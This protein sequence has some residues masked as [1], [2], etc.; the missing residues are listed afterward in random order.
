MQ[1]LGYVLLLV[2]VTAVSQGSSEPHSNRPNRAPLPFADSE[3]SLLPTNGRINGHANGKTNG[4]TNGKSNG[5]CVL[6]VSTII[7][8]RL[9]LLRQTS[10]PAASAELVHGVAV[11][12]DQGGQSFYK[13]QSKSPVAE[14]DNTLNTVR[15]Y[16]AV[17]HVHNQPREIRRVASNSQVF[18]PVAH[19]NGAFYSH[20]GPMLDFITFVTRGSKKRSGS[21]RDSSLPSLRETVF[22]KYPDLVIAAE[23]KDDPGHGMGP[24]PKH[25]PTVNDWVEW[26]ATYL[27]QVK[28]FGLPVVP[29]AKSGS[30][31]KYLQLIQKY[32][33]LLDGLILISPVH[34]SIKHH[35]DVARL[36]QFADEGEFVPNLWGFEWAVKMV[37]QMDFHKNPNPFNGVP[38]LSMYGGMD[39]EVSKEVYQEFD[40]IA[41]NVPSGDIARSIRIAGGGH[42]LLA[43][44][45][46]YPSGNDLM[47][48]FQLHARN[49]YNLEQNPSAK[50]LWNTLR[51]KLKSVF[52]GIDKPKPA[53]WE[54]NW[55]SYRT[56]EEIYALVLPLLSGIFGAYSD[57]EPPSVHDLNYASLESHL[58][59]YEFLQDDV[60]PRFELKRP[61]L[62]GPDQRPS[63]EPE[64]RSVA[65]GE[66]PGSPAWRLE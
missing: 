57:F 15:F 43:T 29:L 21:T 56:N 20:S 59:I 46:N 19:G 60:I 39:Y 7:E 38:V 35:E 63:R 44:Q 52:D 66:I 45:P 16:G 5:H 32:P 26:E 55:A 62:N 33:D 25:F 31:A 42:N 54:T 47:Y 64:I 1:W 36:Y 8:D 48:L 37:Q 30:T 2:C 65:L 28:A 12:L 10:A 27:R 24:D 18:M 40:R 50:P 13:G 17:E 11:A 49:A 61:K 23:A 14:W 3:S 53:D 51:A 4:H 6:S 22:E 34:P 41:A 58:A 9:A